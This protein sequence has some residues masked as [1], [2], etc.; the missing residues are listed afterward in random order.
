[1]ALMSL[2]ITERPYMG[3]ADDDCIRMLMAE[4]YAT[5]GRLRA[6]SPA[7]FDSMRHGRYWQQELAGDYSWMA[8]FRTWIARPT[9]SSQEEHLV[10]AV[11]PGDDGEVVLVVHPAF[12]LI[13]D[14]M[15]AWTEDHYRATRPGT[16]LRLEVVDWDVARQELLRTRGWTRLGPCWLHRTRSLDRDLS[17]SA[18]PAGYT[19]HQVDHADDGDL[20]RHCAIIN[21]VFNRD[22]TLDTMPFIVRRP[23]PHEYWAA[24]APDGDFAAWCGIWLDTR[25]RWAEF[26]PV[27]THPD[28]RRKGLAQAVMY[29]GMERMRALGMRSAFVAPWHDAEANR[30][31][32]AVGLDAVATVSQWEK[33]L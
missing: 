2:P 16:R 12:P 15:L 23:T 19:L 20:R 7:R 13:E 28:H 33:A 17:A 4:S 1:M 21:A 31:Y 6:W 25:N 8:D 10:G 27:G 26:E 30:L 3:E 14:E 22:I 11:H 9:L 5:L 18:L 32:A 24:V 29:Q